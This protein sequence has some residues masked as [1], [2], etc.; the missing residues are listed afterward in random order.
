MSAG[1]VG[2]KQSSEVYAQRIGMILLRGGYT[3]RRIASELGIAPQTLCRRLAGKQTITKE[4]L[5]AAERLR[6][7]AYEEKKNPR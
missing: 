6:D 3:H 1:T 7:I 2:G 4:S 5:L